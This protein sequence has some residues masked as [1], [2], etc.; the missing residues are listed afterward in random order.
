MLKLIAHAMIVFIGFISAGNVAVE[1]TDRIHEASNNPFKILRVSAMS[2]RR[3]FHSIPCIAY[4]TDTK[5]IYD[6]EHSTAEPSITDKRS[7]S[8]VISMATALPL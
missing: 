3:T 6:H 1:M 5:S 4:N 8:P 7:G 2:L